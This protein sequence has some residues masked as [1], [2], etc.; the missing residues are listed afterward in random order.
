L[1]P[2]QQKDGGDD[3]ASD[4]DRCHRRNVTASQPGLTPATRRAGER[5]NDGR[6]EIQQPRQ[7]LRISMA[8]EPLRERRAGAE[9]HRSQQATEDTGT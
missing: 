8:D 2:D 4:D 1:K 6:A 5:Q 7:Q 9:R 3:T